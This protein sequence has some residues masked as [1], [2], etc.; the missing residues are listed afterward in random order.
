M[1]ASAMIA[2]V[3][4]I[5]EPLAGTPRDLDIVVDAA[6]RARFVLIGEASHGTF[7]ALPAMDVA[8]VDVLDF[9]GWLRGWNDVHDP[10]RKVGF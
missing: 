6:D 5:A 4:S 3:R 8:N 1:T 9:V 10:D 7:R 2:S